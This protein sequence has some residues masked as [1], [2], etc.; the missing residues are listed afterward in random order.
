[1]HARRIVLVLKRFRGAE[2]RNSEATAD[3]VFGT[4]VTCHDRLVRDRKGY[5]GVRRAAALVAGSH[6][7]GL[8]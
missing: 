3:F 4:S 8:A 5:R 6:Y 1:M 2:D 7:E